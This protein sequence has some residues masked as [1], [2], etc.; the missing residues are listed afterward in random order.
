MP[1]RYRLKNK[2]PKYVWTIHYKG[3]GVA[4]R[5]MTTSKAK[6]MTKKRNVKMV[7]P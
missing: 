3:G 1:K 5:R 7:S 4:R 6:Y 2:N